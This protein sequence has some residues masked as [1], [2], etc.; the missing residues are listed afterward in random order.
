MDTN[1]C[2]FSA[3]SFAANACA[4]S[5]QIIRANSALITEK[6]IRGNLCNSWFIYQ[7]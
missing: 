5:T 1:L 6:N 3:H 4:D 7:T 2:A